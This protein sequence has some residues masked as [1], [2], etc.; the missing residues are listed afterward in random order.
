LLDTLKGQ[1][2]T[3]THSV[4]TKG[5]H[6]PFVLGVQTPSGERL[7]LAIYAF[8]ISME[9]G[10]RFAFLADL[11]GERCGT[12][13]LWKDPYGVMQTHLVGI[14]IE[15][16]VIVGADAV[17]NDPLTSPTRFAF[18]NNEMDAIRSR[19]WHA[20]EHE[21]DDATPGLEP[22]IEILV[23]FRAQHLLNYL[24]YEREAQG[25]DPGHRHLLAERFAPTQL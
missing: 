25:E 6:L 22:P 3:V 4:A 20:W 10:P 19:G 5:Q 9:P 8:P 18:S 2:D 24:R 21:P 14:D 23:G 17:Y 1:G 7:G 16:G 11:G 15:Q 13:S 12:E